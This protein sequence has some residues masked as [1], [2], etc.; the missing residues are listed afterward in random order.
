MV[1]ELAYV[2]YGAR[3]GEQRHGLGASVFEFRFQQCVE[4]SREAFSKA[5]EGDDV[6]VGLRD[7]VVVDVELFREATHGE[8]LFE[9]AI[10]PATLAV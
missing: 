7:D 3:G 1:E 2:A 4:G 10:T 5:H 8:I 6:G 9:G